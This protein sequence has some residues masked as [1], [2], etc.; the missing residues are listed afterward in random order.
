MNHSRQSG[1]SLVEVAIAAAIF[2]ALVV[3]IS[4]L[5]VTG[6]DAQELGRRIS[7]MTE[8]AQD[9]TDDLRLELVSSSRLYSNDAEGQELL[10]L[11][12]LTQAPA[13][14]ASRRLPTVD[15]DGPFRQDTVGDEITGN[16]ILFSYLAWRD[17]YRCV[18]GTEH[19]VDVYRIAHY[20]LS[21]EG[22]GPAAG[23]RGGLDLVHFVSEPLA[24]GAA[25]DNI[26]ST[27]DREEVA[28]HLLNGTP[29]LEGRSHDPIQVVW[30]RSSSPTA[31]GALRQID[32]DGT[33]SDT[34]LSGTNRPDP[35]AILPKD[36]SARG[37]TPTGRASV[38]TNFD[39]EAPG[40]SRFAVRDDANGFPHG[41][42]AQIVGPSAARQLLWHIV[43][44]DPVRK[45]P[46]AWSQV[47]TVISARDR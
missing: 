4:T 26:L 36:R 22:G 15:L 33:L 44:I 9:V 28:R 43:L 16:A 41:L 13:P 32:D 17:R 34:V 39:L 46:P 14:I 45:G 38:A 35:W 40:I 11:L 3:V 18:S 19:L 12:D 2:M 5:A 37:D 1:F 25:I 23:S 24:D 7:K 6:T 29:D 30:R 10:D 20:Y 27:A 31:L 21:D 8:I 47:Q 42:E